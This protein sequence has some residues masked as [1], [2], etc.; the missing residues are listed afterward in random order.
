[1]LYH[2]LEAHCKYTQWGQL[3]CFFNQLYG[4]G[5][6]PNYLNRCVI[7]YFTFSSLL[8]MSQFGSNIQVLNSPLKKSILVNGMWHQIYGLPVL[9]YILS[10]QCHLQ[11]YPVRPVYT[12]VLVSVVSASVLISM[13]LI[14]LKCVRVLFLVIK[15]RFLLYSWLYGSR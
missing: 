14:S 3:C 5:S 15:F 8:W 12:Y 1:M 7:L 9:L 2:L 13:V 4:L 11:L 6:V 10:V